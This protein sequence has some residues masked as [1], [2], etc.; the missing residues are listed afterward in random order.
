MNYK[1]FA[2]D[3]PLD[4]SMQFTSAEEIEEELQN[5]GVE[6]KTRQ[7]GKGS[8]QARM[9]NRSTEQAE[10]FVDRYSTALSLQLE[11]PAGTVGILFP[12]SANEQFLNC[13]EE[14]SNSALIAFPGGSELDIVTAG[15]AGS[16]AIGVSEERFDEMTQILCS[17]P[18]AVRLEQM[19]V[20]RGG[21]A[22]LNALRKAI[23]ELVV[24]P[25]S[26]PS[27][28]HLTNLL[29]ATIVWMENSLS[30]QR[31]ERI[32]LN[33]NRTRVAK[34][35]REYIEGHY[36]R[37]VSMEDLCRAT[38]VS[39]RTL[40]RS[41]REYFDLTIMDYLKM[42]RLDAAHRELASAHPSEYSVSNIA[43]RHGSTHFGRFS[44][45]FRERF[46]ES[47]SKTLA[48]QSSKKS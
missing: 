15:P 37:T 30:Q 18:G 26:D 24:Y 47:P 40:Q 23:L 48:M 39:V 36:N 19:T 25:E 21:T 6:Q 3:L 43:M 13:G 28:E 2:V 27:P 10:L 11:L 41:F 33:G 29:A 4:R 32:M 35:T 7:L 38:D 45:E 12:R 22:Q 44:I 8:F 42:V 17:E 16:E 5:N 20:I 9:A 14:V 1:D 46:G 31:P 34:Q